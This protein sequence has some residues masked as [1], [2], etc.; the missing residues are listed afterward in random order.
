MAKSAIS[1]KDPQLLNS[2]DSKV[3]EVKNLTK[4]F[5]KFTAVD[6]VSFS[7]GDGEILGVLG[8]NGAGKT[9]TIQM[10]LGVMD[11]TE[12]EIS[13]FGKIFKNHREEILKQINFSSTYISLPWQFTS[14]ET[15]D[16]F[17][18]LYE[19]PDSKKR[20]EKLMQE[21]EIEHLKNK[22]F[23]DLSA[24]EKTR[25]LLTKAFLNY[26]RIILLD[27]PTASLD[28]E[29][30]VKIR[31]FLKKERKEYKVSMFFT[32]HNMAEVEEM[33]DRVII[34]NH[35]KIIVEDTPENLAGRLTGCELELLIKNDEGKAESYFK[36]KKIDFRKERRSFFIPIEE[37]EI[38]NFLVDLQKAKINYE[39]ISINKAG[40]ED[41][42]LKVIRKE[43]MNE[44][45]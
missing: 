19:V 36:S 17:A 16:V 38:G 31:E 13:Y 37:A 24:G 39:Q 25:L 8:P 22:K 34:I 18:R 10:L 26:P 41:F 15:L 4:S 12:G 6:S 14:L 30:A 27:E 29:I 43:K 21:F 7:I 33:C 20:I 23:F 35:G 32:S 2:M 11:P 42:F 40:L 3:L 1:S 28:P 45:E 5:G 44:L 9:T